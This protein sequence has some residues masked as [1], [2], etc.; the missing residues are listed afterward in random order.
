MICA[1]GKTWIA[2]AYLFFGVSAFLLSLGLP[3]ALKDSQ[4]ARIDEEV[5]R[6]RRE[7]GIEEDE[8]RPA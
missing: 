2:R 7:E 1:E 6:R 8:N 5:Q 3:K 4:K